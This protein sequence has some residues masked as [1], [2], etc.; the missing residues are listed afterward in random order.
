MSR[1]EAKILLTKENA[2]DDAF[3]T[4][5]TTTTTKTDDDASKNQKDEFILCI[6]EYWKAKRLKYVSTH[7]FLIQTR[8]KE[9]SLFN[10][11]FWVSIKIETSVDS[12]CSHGQIGRG[13]AAQ[14][15][16]SRLSATHREDANTQEPQDRGAIV[17]EDAHTQARSHQSP[18]TIITNLFFFYFLN[19]NN[20]IN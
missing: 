11:V 15:S 7:I 12:D 4:P 13:H 8:E 19:K 6:Y 16:V 2:N 20:R 10:L 17:R 5:T 18:V 1:D 9:E 14:Q 3:R